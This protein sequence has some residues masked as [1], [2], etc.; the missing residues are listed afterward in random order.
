MVLVFVVAK[1]LF[2]ISIFTNLH[3]TLIG[4]LLAVSVFTFIGML[5]GFLF[6]S[7]EEVTLLSILIGT[8]M[9][10]VSNV[11]LPIESMPILVQKI[12]KFNP[13]MIS[14]EV[15]KQAI[16]FEDPFGLVIGKLGLLLFYAII[17]LGATFYLQQFKKIETF[18]RMSVT[19]ISDYIVKRQVPPEKYLKLGS[20][21]IKSKEDML[22]ALKKMK[23]AEFEKIVDIDKNPFVDW[24]TEVYKDTRLARRLSNKSKEGMIQVLEIHLSIRRDK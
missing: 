8:M 13:F 17:L 18:S 12:V 21:V 11:I 24:I 1:F 4:I 10:V 6:K 19:T 23:T 7:Q 14:S 3:F 16:V 2:T 5:I 9:L 15:I 22:E 20:I